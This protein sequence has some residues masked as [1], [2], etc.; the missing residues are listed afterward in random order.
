MRRVE[1]NSSI[2]DCISR[3]AKITTCLTEMGE[4]HQAIPGPLFVNLSLF[5]YLSQMVAEKKNHLCQNFQPAEENKK[6]H[7]WCLHDAQCALKCEP[8]KIICIHICAMM[9]EEDGV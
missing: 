4:I 1:E 7:G 3:L 5:L 9:W 6:N 2:L 8:F